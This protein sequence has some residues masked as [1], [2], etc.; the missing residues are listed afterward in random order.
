[1]RRLDGVGAR[2]RRDRARDARDTRPSPARE[3][4]PVDG[5]R[6]QLR[7][8]LGS[9]RNGDSAAARAPRERAA[10]RRPTAPPAVLRARPR[11]VSA[12]RRRGRTDRA[13]RARASPDTP[14]SR[15]VVH[16]HSTAGSPR[17]PH[18]HMFIVADQHGSAPGR[19]RDRRPARPTRRRPR[20]AGAGTR[21]R[22]AGTPAARPGA[23]R[24]DER[25]TPHPAAGSILHR[26]SPARM[27]RDAARE[28]ARRTTS[29][30]PG[31]SRPATEW[32]RVT[33]SASARVSAGRIPGKPARE[34]RLAGA[35]RPHQQDVVRAGG[36]DLECTAGALLS[37][38]VRQI[39]LQRRSVGVLEQRLVRRSLD[40]ASKVRDDLGQVAD[41]HR[42]DARESSLGGRLG[43]ADDS[44]KTGTPRSFG[45][46]E[47]PRHRA[48]PPVEG[49]LADGGVVD[50]PLRRKLPASHR[51]RRAR[52]GG[53]IPI[54]PC[55]MRPARD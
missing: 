48:N 42:L 18:G 19:A 31:G 41:G 10:R 40:L 25:A 43:R 30:R 27:R 17:A 1:M 34:H 12:S 6:Q 8:R 47:R 24:R 44:R 49:E 53:R 21:A 16:A 52:S 5:A 28:T 37:A 50:E 3:R 26:R 4:Q 55:A 15:C 14:A 13:A 45:D 32:I 38:H 22:S 9:A 7:G 23:A 33:S 20:A 36:S 51:A 54:P 39:G 35:R 46:G 11:A 2:E 29:A